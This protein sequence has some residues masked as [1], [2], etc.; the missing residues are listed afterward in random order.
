MQK[1]KRK[2][3]NTRGLPSEGQ[4]SHSWSFY[5]QLGK[6]A[7]PSFL[8][9]GRSGHQTPYTLRQKREKEAVSD[10]KQILLKEKYSV[11]KEPF[12]KTRQKPIG[13][14]IQKSHTLPLTNTHIHVHTTKK[15]TCGEVSI[16]TSWPT[17]LPCQSAMDG[18]STCQFSSQKLFRP[19]KK[20]KKKG[21]K[22]SKAKSW[23]LNCPKHA[24]TEGATF[25]RS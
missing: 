22:M 24:P 20:N 10:I 21:A 1:E 5:G 12:Q 17:R 14:F 19:K 9:L 25:Y 11:P 23:K 2:N 18:K 4:T 7:L 3:K 16:V 13:L 6:V 15:L 8:G